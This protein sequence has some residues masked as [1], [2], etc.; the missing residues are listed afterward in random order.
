MARFIV[1]ALFLAHSFFL[2][3]QTPEEKAAELNA[4]IAAA[5]A[6]KAALLQQQEVLKLEMIQRELES[7]GLPTPLPGNAIVR[8]SAMVLEYAEQYEQARW[9]MH[10]ISPDI[11]SGQVFRT[12]DFREDPLVPSGSAVEADYFLKTL[13]PD[14]TWKYDGF[15]YDRGHLAPSADFRW[16]KQALSESYFY[17]NM[18]PQKAE[19]NRG[20]WGNLEDRIRGYLYRNR[21]TELYVV[22]GPVLTPDLPVIERGMNKV[23]IP[24]YYW[25]VAVDVKN[26]R[27]IGFYMPNQSISYPLSSFAVTIDQVEEATGIDFFSNLPDSIEQKIENQRIIEDWLPENAS[28]DVEPIYA[29]NLPKGAYNT[30]QAK[31][32]A[33]DS[34]EYTV[35]GTVVSARKSRAGNI[36]LNLDKQFPNQIF[37]VFIRKEHIVN[38]PFDVE[39]ELKGKTIAVKGKII[40]LDGTPAMFIENNKKLEVFEGD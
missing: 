27:G 14:S 26:Q 19:F 18:S 39:Q 33:G 2:S 6:Q 25:K 3:A 16:S 5:D 1:L 23:H 13:L 15:G 7:I 22:T 9:V 31:N 11:L 37:T 21:E 32:L 8:H 36:L 30:V 38:F 35:C 10:I 29:F 12:N 20:G 4:A 40:D 28:G 17:S 24:K 34:R